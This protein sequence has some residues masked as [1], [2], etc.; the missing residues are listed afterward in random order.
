M[1]PNSNKA[2]RFYLIVV[3]VN[4]YY[5]LPVANCFITSF[6]GW[7]LLPYI[8]KAHQSCKCNYIIYQF[9][10]GYTNTFIR[11]DR[12]KKYKIFIYLKV[13][14]VHDKGILIIFLFEVLIHNSESNWTGFAYISFDLEVDWN[15]MLSYHIASHLLCA[16]IC[17]V[18]VENYMLI[19]F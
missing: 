12:V 13:Y 9:N 2:G 3:S 14:Y 4:F 17:Y 18:C 15:Y 16:K 8:S 19:E 1:N 6:Q 7:K 5:S 11:P 10:T